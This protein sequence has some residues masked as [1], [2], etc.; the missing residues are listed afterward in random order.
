MKKYKAQLML[1][2]HFSEIYKFIVQMM[3]N[4]FRRGSIGRS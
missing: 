1:F 4:T 3:P 2:F